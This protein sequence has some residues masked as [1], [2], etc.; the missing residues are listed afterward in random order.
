[1]LTAILILVLQ[2]LDGD[3][4]L[5]TM[6]LLQVVLILVLYLELKAHKMLIV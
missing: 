4:Y 6:L 1:M 5:L 2:T 3:N